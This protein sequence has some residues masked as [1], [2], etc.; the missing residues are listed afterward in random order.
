MSIFKMQSRKSKISGRMGKWEIPEKFHKIL[1]I[2][3]KRI[4]L[5]VLNQILKETKG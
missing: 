3:I 2:S 4:L 5:L 1:A